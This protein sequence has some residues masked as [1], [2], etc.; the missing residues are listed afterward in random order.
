MMH[1][2]FR[3]IF[4]TYFTLIIPFAYSIATWSSQETDG[5]NWAF[6]YTNQHKNRILDKLKKSCLY[7]TKG[8]LTW[9]FFSNTIVLELEI[10]ER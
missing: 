7:C 5:A 10:N 8:Q 9:P 2:F 4:A 6:F 3:S 1:L